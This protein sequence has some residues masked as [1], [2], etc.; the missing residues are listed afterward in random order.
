MHVFEY[1]W[2]VDGNSLVN[3][4]NHLAVCSLTK[5]HLGLRV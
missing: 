1:D 4:G 5:T 3:E 2:S